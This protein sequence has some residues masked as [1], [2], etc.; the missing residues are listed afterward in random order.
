[1]NNLIRS[2]QY[3][4]ANLQNLIIKDVNYSNFDEVEK[5]VLKAAASVLNYY[6]NDIDD[7]LQGYSRITPKQL[8]AIK[9][10]YRH[11]KASKEKKKEYYSLTREMTNRMINDIKPDLSNEQ[12]WLD[13]YQIMGCVFA[14]GAWN[15]GHKVPGP[16]LNTFYQV[17]KVIKNKKGLQIIV[18]APE[19][20]RGAPI[21][22]CRGTTPHKV[23]NFVDD[24]QAQIGHYSLQGSYG[25]ILDAFLE[26]A[27][28][29]G[30][31]IITGHSLGGAI[32]Q[33]LLAGY[34][35]LKTVAEV[36]LIQSTYTFNSP[37]SGEEME[38][39]YQKN[40][41]KMLEEERPKLYR[42]Y[43][44][45]DIV[46][47]AGGRHLK[48]DKVYQVGR[49][50]ISNLLSPVKMITEAHSWTQLISELEVEEGKESTVRRTLQM[51]IEKMR[52][53]V[54]G[55]FKFILTKQLEVRKEVK[56]HTLKVKKFIKTNSV[57]RIAQIEKA[58]SKHLKPGPMFVHP[59]LIA[60]AFI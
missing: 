58:T 10:E 38:R 14:Y 47:L 13:Y 41:N 40:R 4:L 27:E 26:A 52:N 22:C 32:A 39:K 18:L 42:Y 20:F 30:P 1:M 24:F 37:G 57:D 45:R 9:L 44:G 60:F 33:N 51:V 59:G 43:D 6:G 15:I 31:V 50:A 2:S 34:C 17:E 19:G 12:K 49:F 48:A 21:I 29:Y 3:N 56:K 35:H 55:I 46:T 7:Y 53:I 11:I 36:P 54:S 8:S 16:L 5:M 23:H 28:K 25:E